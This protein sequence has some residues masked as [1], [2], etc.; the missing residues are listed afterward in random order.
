MAA[1]LL[2]LSCVLPASIA[3]A[4]SADPHAL[5]EDRCGRCHGHAGAFARKS[6]AIRDGRVVGRGSGVPV[7]AFLRRHHGAPSE[8]ETALLLDMF[9]GQIERGALFQERCRICHASAR[10]LARGKLILRDGWLVG[11][12]TG[13]DMEP[14]LNAHG[15]LS[16]AEAETIRRMLVWQLGK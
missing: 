13:A 3:R 6:L 14:F 4:Q 10:K 16:A 2:C 8:M 1:M 12:Y 9:R 15:R 5:F 7:R 11:R